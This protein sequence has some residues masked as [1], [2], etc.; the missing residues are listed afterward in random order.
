MEP[1][2]P[3]ADR[4]ALN[5]V[6]GHVFNPSDFVVRS[7]GVCELNPEMAR[8]VVDLPPNFH[9]RA[10]RAL[11]GFTP[12]GAG[13]ATCDRRSWSG[14]RSRSRVVERLAA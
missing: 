5:F 2:R 7:D 6:K 10:I 13:G 3:K 11:A 4:A 8:M 1:E 9:P 14:L 12:W